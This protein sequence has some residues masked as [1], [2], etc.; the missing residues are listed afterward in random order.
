MAKIIKYSQAIVSVNQLSQASKGRLNVK[1]SLSKEIILMAKD[2][3]RYSGDFSRP[4]SL[5]EIELNSSGIISTLKQLEIEDPA[6]AES[7][8]LER[9]S[10]QPLV[11]AV[12]DAL[13]PSLDA[14][15]TKIDSLK[16]HQSA[17]KPPA[18]NSNLK[19]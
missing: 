16:T 11:D 15:S 6:L 4:S 17:P 5:K 12:L 3:S 18:S 8:A 10:L 2:V 14:M 7:R 13:K 1:R 19:S 9:E